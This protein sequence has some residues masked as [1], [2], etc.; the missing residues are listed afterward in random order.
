MI[1]PKK[2]NKKY[3]VRCNR[4]NPF[5]NLTKEGCGSKKNG[6]T[7]TNLG[8]VRALIDADLDQHQKESDS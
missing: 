1:K 7:E 5:C 3:Y 2:N 6:R 8:E 4:P